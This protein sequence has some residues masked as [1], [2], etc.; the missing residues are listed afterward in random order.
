M[1]ASPGNRLVALSARQGV[2]RVA[3]KK[4][5]KHDDDVL[6]SE[7]NPAEVTMKVP[8]TNKT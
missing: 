7:T 6:G 8:E 1:F 2:L 5:R 3:E 4:L